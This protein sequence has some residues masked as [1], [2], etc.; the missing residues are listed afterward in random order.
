MAKNASSDADK[1]T[2]LERMH[3]D[4][5]MV[6]QGR[7]HPKI[8]NPVPMFDEAVRLVASR[9]GKIP[10]SSKV[11][12]Y[13]SRKEDDWVSDEYK[14]KELFESGKHVFPPSLTAVDGHLD[15]LSVKCGKRFNVGFSDGTYDASVKKLVGHRFEYSPNE[16]TEYGL[17]ADMYL[18][19]FRSL[20]KGEWE[21]HPELSGFIDSF[22]DVLRMD[23]NCYIA[24]ADIGRAYDLNF[25]LSYGGHRD[26]YYNWRRDVEQVGWLR[27]GAPRRDRVRAPVWGT[28]LGPRLAARLSGAEG[29]KGAEAFKKRYDDWAESQDNDVKHMEPF[30]RVRVFPDGAMFIRVSGNPMD[31][32]YDLND[33]RNGALLNAVWLW[34]QYRQA[35][36]I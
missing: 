3:D 16:N 21:P 26:G 9:A 36:M 23:P 5:L 28:Y 24:L 2:P 34:D 27:A 4:P 22:I 12:S 7:F 13:M 29:K 20:M 30:E 18:N 19:N 14:A 33:D 35:G 32:Y 6:I 10:T 8:E 11:V 25:G 31:C 1:P 15:M 17:D